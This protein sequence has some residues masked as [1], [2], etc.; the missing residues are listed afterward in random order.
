MSSL[1]ELLF[2]RNTPRWIVFLIDTAICLLSLLIAYQVRFN[3]DVPDIE[4]SHLRYS[5]PTL[6]GV[7]IT[8]FLVS[9]SYKGIIRYTGSRDAV[10][11]F[12][13]ISVGSLAIVA[14]NIGSYL[15]KG[16]YLVPFSILIIDTVFSVFA[17]ASFR[18]FVKLMYQEIINPTKGKRSVIIY[19]AGEAGAIT[20]RTLDRDA[21]SRFKVIAFVDDDPVKKGKT[22]EGITIYNTDH[23]LDDLLRANDVAQVIISIQQ[24]SSAKRQELVD[25]CTAQRVN[26]LNVPP[27]SS[28]TN[29]ELRF[30]Q[31][32]NLKIEDLLE[33]DPILLHTDSIREALTGK[34]ILVT[35]GAGSIGS[36]IVRQ[37][38]NYDPRRV[39]ALDQAESA[40]YDLELQIHEKFRSD[41]FETVIGDVRQSDRMRRVFDHFRPEVI[42]HAAAYKHVPVME[43]NPSEAILTNVHG[44]RIIADL[45]HEFNAEKFVLVSTD[46]AVNPTNIMGATKRIAEIY[47]QSLGRVSKTRFITTRFGNVLDSNGSV[48]PRFKKQIEEGGPVTVTHPDITRYFMTIPEACQLV[49]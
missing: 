25:R 42:F 43:R 28:W 18:A 45:A 37:L 34:T 14:L 16:F 2:R 3:F 36:E 22:L 23:D 29:G 44:T 31:I 12:Y 19:G 11:I 32:R 48:I 30:S 24:L 26:V 46:K 8:G 39:I 35:G 4:L 20:K 17:L 40:A 33:R 49:L 38:L 21:G 5:L 15:I 47:C 41:R 13:S 27:V 6:I 9:G 1:K 7:R 10:R